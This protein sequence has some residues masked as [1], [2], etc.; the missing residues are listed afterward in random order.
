ML[1]SSFAK[2]LLAFVAIIFTAFLILSYIITSMI[3]GYVN[4]ELDDKLILTSELVV[5]SLESLPSP[6]LTSPEYLEDVKQIVTPIINFDSRYEILISDTSG[7]VVLTSI[8]DGCVDEDGNKIPLC[9]CSG[10]FFTVNS[11]SFRPMKEDDRTDL[12]V[13]RGN[14]DGT[15]HSNS[16]VY[17][18]P[19]IIEG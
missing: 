5:D 3:R 4:K 18:R 6:D 14:L 17:A 16:L 11:G 1:K 2:Y 9:N 10:G 15:V 19:V 13:Y 7:K 12:L 8:G